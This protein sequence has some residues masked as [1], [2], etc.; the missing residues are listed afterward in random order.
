MTNL[1]DSS[2]K[3]ILMKKIII[4]YF[5]ASVSLFAQEN[6]LRKANNYFLTASFEKAA[7]TYSSLISEGNTDPLVLKRAADS[8][9]YISDFENAATHYKLI[10]EKQKESVA[11]QYLFRYAQSLKAIGKLEES[12]KWMKIYE[13]EV[14]ETVYKANIDK[15]ESIK[16]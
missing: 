2:K 10:V 16:K 6:Q 14:P 1:L 8:Y 5:L 12:N 4:I 7:T 9:Y 3:H 11:E 15:L 13:K